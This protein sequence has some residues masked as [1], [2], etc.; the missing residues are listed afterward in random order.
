MQG[1]D[2]KFVW[3]GNLIESKGGNGFLEAFWAFIRMKN[4]NFRISTKK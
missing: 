1:K 3:V 4:Y 2:S